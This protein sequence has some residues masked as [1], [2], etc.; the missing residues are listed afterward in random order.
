MIT[1]LPTLQFLKHQLY[2]RHNYRNL[3]DFI[4][5]HH[6]LQSPFGTV[7]AIHVFHKRKWRLREAKSQP[8]R[9]QNKERDGLFC[10]HCGA[11]PVSC[12]LTSETGMDFTECHK[13]ASALV[14]LPAGRFPVTPPHFLQANTIYETVFQMSVI[15]RMEDKQ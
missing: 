7:A 9:Q 3:V 11:C 5:L 4:L 2:Y 6:S 12:Q 10:P 1:M 8:H 14:H 15:P 13:T